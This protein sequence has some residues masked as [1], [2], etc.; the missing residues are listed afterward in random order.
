MDFWSDRQEAEVVVIRAELVIVTSMYGVLDKGQSPA[1]STGTHI[2]VN[3]H[4][5]GV[6]G[7]LDPEDSTS[8][9]GRIF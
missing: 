1:T 9:H 2:T 4:W 8:H 7:G 6:V 3:F 5:I